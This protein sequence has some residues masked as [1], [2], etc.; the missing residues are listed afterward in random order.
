MDFQANGGCPENFKMDKA[1]RTWVRAGL[2]LADGTRRGLTVT[3]ILR[4]I[5]RHPIQRLGR[6][7]NWKSALLS[8][9]LRAGIFFVVNLR[10]GFSA[11][12]GAMLAELAL[13]A[14][15]SGYCGALTQ[16]FRH[17]TPRWAAT[18]AVMI[19]LPLANHTL[20]FLLHWLRGTPEL[21][22]SIVASLSFTAISSAFNL[23]VMQRGALIVGG[24]SR[25]LRHDLASLPL[26]AIGFCR[27]IAVNPWKQA[28]SMAFLISE[29]VRPDAARQNSW[30]QK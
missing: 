10:A 8:S 22:A 5:T 2:P 15:L 3:G 16:A 7:W 14:V 6:Q 25:S 4:D 19:L 24:E 12:V 21:L 30:D 20:E 28:C 27:D 29:R 23:Y 17:A 13:R 26:L 18:V 1:P 11:A 9:I